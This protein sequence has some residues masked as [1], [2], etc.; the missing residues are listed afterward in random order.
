M[1]YTNTGYIY[2]FIMPQTHK[3]RDM[4]V[5]RFYDRKADRI[6]TETDSKF[7]SEF[8]RGKKSHNL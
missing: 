6:N 2:K 5:N 8:Y 7:L 3:F 1:H 4:G